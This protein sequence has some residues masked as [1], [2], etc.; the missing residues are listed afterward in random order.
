[1]G[2]KLLDDCRLV[3]RGVVVQ[4]VIHKEFIPEG[5]TIN[6]VYYKGVMERFLSRIQRI[7]PGKCESGDLFLLHEECQFAR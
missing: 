2:Q 7:R 3:G 1:M 6:A 5:E 4:G